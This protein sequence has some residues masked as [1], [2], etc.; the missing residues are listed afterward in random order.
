MA[1]DI[2]A[3]RFTDG[4]AAAAT[5][6]AAAQTL[7][8]AGNMTLAGTAATFGGTNLGQKITLV[9]GGNISAVTFTITGTDQAGA[10]QSE[11]LTGPNASTVTSTKY[12]NTITQIA[13]SGAVGTNTSSGVAADQ[14][15]TLF[16]GRTRVRGMHAVNAGAGTILFNNSSIDGSEILGM[17]VDAGDLD[18]YIPDDGM[19]FDSGAFIKVNVGVITGLTVFFD[20]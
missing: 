17:P 10:S 5:V 1:T 18:P 7:G 15:G 11:D 9:S 3:K 12:Y 20:G 6:I 16:A 19:V 13:A 8:G 14:G 2:K 4:T